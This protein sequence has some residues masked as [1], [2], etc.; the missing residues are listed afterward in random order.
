MNAPTTDSLEAVGKIEDARY[1]DVLAWLTV[2][3]KIAPVSE[4]MLGRTSTEK[5]EP[6]VLSLNRLGA[7]DD[8]D[9]QA[10][11]CAVS[12]NHPCP[13]DVM[14]CAPDCD[15]VAS[16]SA[17]F[18]K[19]HRALVL[20][21]D[22]TEAVVGLVDPF[23][24][25]A[26][27]GLAFALRRRIN[28]VVMRAGDQRRFFAETYD[29]AGANWKLEENDRDGSALR[30][31]LEFDRD[32]PV[33]RRVADWLTRAVEARA[34]DVHIEPRPH[35]L[36]IRYRIDG[37]LHTVATEQIEA[38]GA[39]LARV[40]VL[41]DLDLGERRSPQDGRTTVVVG[42]RPIDIRVSIVPSVHG[43]AAVLRILDRGGV[44]LDFASLGFA[45]E[46]LTLL[47]ESVSWPHGLFLVTGPTGSG[48]TTTLY[49]A[50]EALR[51]DERKILT[52]EDPVEFHFDHVTQVQTAPKAGVTFASSIRA[53][54]RQDPDV[55]LVGE[56]RDTETAIAA[57]RAALTGHLVL[58]T[59]HAID[60]AR[61]VPRL[62]DMDVEPF[63]LSACIRG[64]LAQR[65]VRR[66]CPD[67]RSERLP[68]PSE[69]AALDLSAGEPVFEPRGCVHCG[70]TGYAGRLAVAEGFEV[71]ESFGIRVRA[72][73]RVAEAARDLMPHRLLEDGK[74][75]V[76][77]GQTSP[78]ELMRVLMG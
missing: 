10:A 33:A 56:I 31:A 45:E 23:D 78:A 21:L 5:R 2:R 32:A 53:F 41:A 63:Q 52:V 75:K 7:L 16:V 25:A 74:R 72:G 9:L 30:S 54:L 42:G 46:E 60:A 64:V 49:A 71:D 13:V 29:T 17:A 35:A 55:I 59:L 70:G 50:L 26:V 40:K 73:D 37:V 68:D 65:L 77:T 66:L 76:R 3:G 43:E 61:A 8:S 57:I 4:D 34:S 15:G 47:R 1:D 44:K 6:R 19:S 28:V 14:P 38:A 39:V 11:F 24:Q 22:D 27:S 67:C 18:L 20:S 48:K 51:G 62:L 12:G 69:I 58:A 36:T